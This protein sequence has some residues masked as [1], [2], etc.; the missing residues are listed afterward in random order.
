M[1]EAELEAAAA[2]VGL[3]L[4]P[5]QLPGVMSFYAAARDMADL[6]DA[7]PLDDGLLDLA[8]VFRLPD[9]AP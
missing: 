3:V 5:G 8:P 4:T 9:P 6:L 2:R 7:V 1:T